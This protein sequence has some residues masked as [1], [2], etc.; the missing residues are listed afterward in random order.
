MYLCPLCYGDGVLYI[1]YL[2]EK[3][4]RVEILSFS[5]TTIQRHEKEMWVMRTSDYDIHKIFQFWVM[6]YVYDLKIESSKI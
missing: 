6:F 1:G 5:L 4:R 3:E 2:G